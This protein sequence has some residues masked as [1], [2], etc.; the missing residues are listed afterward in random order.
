MV[1]II[2]DQGFDSSVA[3]DLY[4]QGVE[5]SQKEDYKGA[6]KH[7]SDA[8]SKDGNF[9]EA[10]V[11]RGRAYSELGTQK[12]ESEYYQRSIADYTKAL[13]VNAKRMF[14]KWWLMYQKL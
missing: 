7:Y 6:V 13:E 8:L 1:K 3:V 14:E 4:K 2:N 10:Y 11:S 5:K 12:S 9:A